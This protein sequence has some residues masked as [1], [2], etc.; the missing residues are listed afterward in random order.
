MRDSWDV[1]LLRTACSMYRVRESR[2]GV[3]LSLFKFVERLHDSPATLVE[4][5]EDENFIYNQ[6]PL[7]KFLLGER[8]L[9]QDYLDELK[10][11]MIAEKM[12]SE[13]DFSARDRELKEIVDVTRHLANDT[14][15]AIARI[16]AFPK[17]LYFQRPGSPWG[18]LFTMTL[19]KMPGAFHFRVETN[20][21]TNRSLENSKIGVKNTQDRVGYE[22]ETGYGFIATRDNLVHIITRG[23][24]ARCIVSY[25]QL[26]YPPNFGGGMYV[27]FLRL[28]SR[29]VGSDSPDA[30]GGDYQPDTPGELLYSLILDFKIGGSGGGGHSRPAQ[31]K[32]AVEEK[33]RG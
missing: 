25:Q 22:Y 16:D 5:D 33:A 26:P 24:G 1:K 30:R 6:E 20:C 14:R 17:S 28:G 31:A 7:R 19:T 9:E 18:E 8:G 3:L 11:F 13:E 4:T 29:P 15:D 12:L 32:L 21:T 23:A 2:S 27:Y 10:R